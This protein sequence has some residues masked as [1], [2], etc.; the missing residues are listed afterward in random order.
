ML[1]HIRGNYTRIVPGFA[2]C[3]ADA[4]LCT[5]RIYDGE[6]D[7]RLFIYGKELQ[8]IETE[9]LYFPEFSHA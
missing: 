5:S 1:T 4:Q 8:S 6:E 2:P 3:S 7:Y 9:K